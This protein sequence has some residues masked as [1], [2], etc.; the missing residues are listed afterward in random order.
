M[1][2]FDAGT[3]LIVQAGFSRRIFAGQNAQSS[4]RQR[5]KERD[6]KKK[7]EKITRGRRRG[8]TAKMRTARV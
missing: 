2:D 3:H 1:A 6:E 5:E 4:E 8:R 7:Y